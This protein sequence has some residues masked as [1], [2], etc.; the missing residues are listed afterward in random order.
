MMAHVL[1]FLP[2][3]WTT[4]MKLLALVFQIYH[5]FTEKAICQD[6]G[7][8]HTISTSIHSSNSCKNQF[9]VWPTWP[10]K[11]LPGLL[12]GCQGPIVWPIFQCHPRMLEGKWSSHA[13]NQHLDMGCWKPQSQP[14][15]VSFL[16][17]IN[18]SFHSLALLSQCSVLTVVL[19][20]SVWSISL[21]SKH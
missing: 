16:S 6:R 2:P 1:G 11:F 14:K 15:F 12:C 17:V 20:T 10:Q 9:W 18:F 19:S 4:G 13:L 21:D 7:I 3:K 5:L 8:S